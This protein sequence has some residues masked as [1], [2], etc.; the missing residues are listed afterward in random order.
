H[1]STAQLLRKWTGS[2]GGPTV[3]NTNARTGGAL[4]LTGTN[5]GLWKVLAAQQFWYVGHAMYLGSSAGGHLLSLWDSLAGAPQFRFKLEPSLV[6]SARRGSA[7]G[8]VLGMSSAALVTGA[9]QY[10]EP[11]V[12][13]D[14]TAGAVQIRLN[15]TEVLNLSGVNTRATANS[16]ADTLVIGHDQLSN[17]GGGINATVDRDDLYVGDGVPPFNTGFLG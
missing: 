6:V 16:S 9:W 13:I 14:P 5:T 1:Y 2:F 10:V 17:D 8:T 15:G 11:F 3:Q 12:K 4:R 7:S